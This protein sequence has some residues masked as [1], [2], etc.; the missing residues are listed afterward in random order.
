MDPDGEHDD[1]AKAFDAAV[2]AIPGRV[3]AAVASRART[4]WPETF[5]PAGSPELAYGSALMRGEIPQKTWP[6]VADYPGLTKLHEG[7]DICMVAD[8]L[9]GDECDRLVQEASGHLIH[10]PVVGDDGFEPSRTSSTRFLGRAGL[11]AAVLEKCEALTGKPARHMET[12]QIG[13]YRP[14]EK[15]DAHFDAVEMGSP[16]GRAWDRNGGQRLATVLIYLNDVQEGGRT[17]FAHGGVAL[18]VAPAKGAAVVFFP[19]FLDRS[20]D[21]RLLHAAEPAVAEKWVLQVWIRE[22]EFRSPA[23]LAGK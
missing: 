18:R 10:S 4:N 15:Y 9:S 23:S 1:G 11:A 19:G 16:D 14:G 17:H 22:R 21:T 12:P 20:V 6:I 2:Q 7:P 13:R 8:F 3:R 5:W